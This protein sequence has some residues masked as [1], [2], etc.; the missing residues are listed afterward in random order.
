[1]DIRTAQEQDRPA[2]A[3]VVVQSFWPLLSGLGESQPILIDLLAAMLVPERFTVAVDAEGQVLGAAALGDAQGY[4][5]EVKPALLR[6]T[7][8][9]IKGS[10]ATKAMGEEVRRPAAFQAGQAAISL[11]SVRESVRNQGVAKAILKHILRQGHYALYT[12]DVIQGSE[13]ALP[14]FEGLGFVHTGREKEKGGSLKGFDFRYLMAYRSPVT[15][16]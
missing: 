4:P 3:Q 14:L 12:L 9:F 10:L 7:F 13:K 1:M 6:K 16:V 8:G 15:S 5:I 2:I 11:V